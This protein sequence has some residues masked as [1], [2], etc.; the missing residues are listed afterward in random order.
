MSSEQFPD[1]DNVAEFL[2]R[3]AEG[4]GY[5]GSASPDRDGLEVEPAVEMDPLKEVQLACLG[6]MDAYHDYLYELLGDGGIEYDPVRTNYL[7]TDFGNPNNICQLLNALIEEAGARGNDSAVE[8][9]VTTLRMLP[10][11][12]RAPLTSAYISAMEAGSEQATQGLHARLS[13]E[14]ERCLH[15]GI[16][17]NPQDLTESSTWYLSRTVEACR[18]AGIAPDT[19]IEQYCFD[20]LHKLAMYVRYLAGPAD[21]IT[22]EERNRIET[23]MADTFATVSDTPAYEYT[24]ACLRSIQ[25]PD[26]R[27][28]LISQY[29]EMAESL[30]Q[31][32]TA[33]LKGVLAEILWGPPINADSL[34]PRLQA[35]PGIIEPLSSQAPFNE[36]TAQWRLDVLALQGASPETMVATLDAYTGKALETNPRNVL[37]PRVRDYVLGTYATRYAKRG[38][39]YSAKAFLAAIHNEVVLEEATANCI[40]YATTPEQLDTIRPDDLTLSFNTGLQ[41]RLKVTEAKRTGSVDDLIAIGHELIQEQP[42]LSPDTDDPSLAPMKKVNEF[43]DFAQQQLGKRRRAGYATEVFEAILGQDRARGLRFGREILSTIRARGSRHDN[44]FIEALSDAL[45]KAG[46]PIEAELRLGIIASR[47]WSAHR[48][49]HLIN[50]LLL[51][52]LIHGKRMSDVARAELILKVKRHSEYPPTPT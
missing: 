31:I 17:D 36:S 4:F 32:Q 24:A 37:P 2:R 29:I 8:Q 45:I 3:L 13:A 10:D 47:D 44:A 14:K 38:D 25:D 51:D 12:N 40:P 43:I 20:A 42:P 15:S 21:R 49:D 1:P 16:L 39:L 11:A 19:W 22:P 5:S 33:V 27:G 52:D 26:I 6:S 48:S 28:R 35:L 50:L 9:Y 41:A 30:P 46:D 34:V 18:D 7:L 23:L